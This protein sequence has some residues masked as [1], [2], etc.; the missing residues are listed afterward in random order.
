M[1]HSDRSFPHASNY[2]GMHAAMA[3]PGVFVCDVT[4]GRREFGRA[5]N[6]GVRAVLR[7]VQDI[8]VQDIS[9]GKCDFVCYCGRLF[10]YLHAEN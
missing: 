4:G 9:R 5:G 8:P 10:V 2:A 6:G 7:A 3:A 1:C